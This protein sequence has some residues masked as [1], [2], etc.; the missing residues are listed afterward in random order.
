MGLRF[1][2]VLMGTF[3]RYLRYC[4]VRE[5]CPQ[6]SGVIR[7]QASG[8]P[9]EKLWPSSS[10]L[11]LSTLGL[12][13]V[14][15]CAEAIAVHMVGGRD[16]GSPVCRSSQPPIK[17]DKQASKQWK[18]LAKGRNQPFANLGEWGWITQSQGGRNPSQPKGC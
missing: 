3:G 11:C 13:G 14:P 2:P 12:H 18:G 10:D 9:Q 8:R 7:A 5:E 16:R 15:M 17:Q 6:L 1:L 4:W